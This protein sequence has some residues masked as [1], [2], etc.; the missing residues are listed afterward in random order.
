VVSWVSSPLAT[1]L[2]LTTLLVIHLGTNYMAVRSVRMRSLNR[3]RANLVFSHLLAYD[4]VLSPSQV[5][6]AERI[7]ELDGVLR[8]ADDSIIGFAKIGASVRECLDSVSSQGT[9]SFWTI[10]SA[11][12][13]RSYSSLTMRHILD[14]FEDEAYALRAVNDD[15]CAR[16]PNAKAQVHIM[17]KQDC[18]AQM[19]LKAWLQALMLAKDVSEQGNRAIHSLPVMD[20]D[21]SSSDGSNPKKGPGDKTAVAVQKNEQLRQGLNRVGDTL[22]RTNKLFDEYA[23]RLQS[24]GWELD[25]AIL[26]THAGPRISCKR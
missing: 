5:S 26:E 15:A 22:Y 8:W 24:A 10:G 1:W 6:K 23:V 11:Y 20:K 3:Q 14:K 4:K 13:G 19:Q 21:D 16:L 2:T 25:H 18:S 9:H 17:L 7:F 12:S